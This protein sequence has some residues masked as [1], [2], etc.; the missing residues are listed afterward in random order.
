MNIE[1]VHEGVRLAY[2]PGRLEIAHEKPLVVLDGAHNAMAAQA[3]AEEVRRLPKRRL[4]LVVGMLEGHEP[5]EFLHALAPLADAVYAT[6]P[7]WQKGQPVERIAAAARR[8]CPEVH[9]ITPPLEAA[10]AA[11]AA[12]APEDLVLVTG[13]FY[14]VGDTS[15][16]HL[17]PGS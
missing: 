11:V 2:L 17:F 7:T 13:S 15:P 3:L 12:A 10:R 4:L 8:Y 16:A 9:S 1:A 6:Q 14:T 5:D